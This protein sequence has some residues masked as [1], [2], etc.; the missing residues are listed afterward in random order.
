[1]KISNGNVSILDQADNKSFTVSNSGTVYRSYNSSG[2]NI[3]GTSYAGAYTIYDIDYS[4][5]DNRMY[6]W[7][8]DGGGKISYWD[9]NTNSLTLLFDPNS[10]FLSGTGTMDQVVRYDNG[11]VYFNQSM[12]L[13]SVENNGSNSR[14]ITSSTDAKSITGIVIV[15]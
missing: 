14:I 4:D 9:L 7:E 8:N 15:D 1:M 3:S 2:G 6:M 12:S 13:F 10:A 11:L 5:L